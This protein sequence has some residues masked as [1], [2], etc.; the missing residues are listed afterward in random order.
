MISV[1][2]N[3]GEK[4]LRVVSALRAGEDRNTHGDTTQGL[5][6]LSAHLFLGLTCFLGLIGKT[7]CCWIAFGIRR[8]R[9]RRRAIAVSG[10]SSV[11][12]ESLSAASISRDEMLR[13]SF[14]CRSK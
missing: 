7:S 6:G 8:H 9:L 14:I 3:F 10:S 2:S 12:S 13:D 1:R 11:S 5:P 4:G